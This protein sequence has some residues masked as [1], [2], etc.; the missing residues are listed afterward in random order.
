MNAPKNDNERLI[1]SVNREREAAAE[2][3][4]AR[5]LHLLGVEMHSATSFSAS[6][7]CGWWALERQTASHPIDGDAARLLVAARHHE[8]LEKTAQSVMRVM[9]GPDAERRFEQGGKGC[10]WVEISR[11]G[12]EPVVAHVR[13]GASGRG[14][15]CEFCKQRP[16]VSLCDSP[17]GGPCSKC[18]G[19]GTRAGFNCRDCAG[20]GRAM[21]NRKVCGKCR[22][23]REPD[24]DYCPDHAERA[25]LKP[26]ASPTTEARTA[27][28]AL[29]LKPMRDGCRFPGAC[30]L[31][32]AYLER[33]SVCW[34]SVE[35]RRLVCENCGGEI[36]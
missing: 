32:G 6:C 13:M 9:G 8:H 16:H 1:A 12:S 36:G 35:K 14:V 31:C 30:L 18:K 27:L 7:S 5:P 4:A 23:H 22:Q 15:R 24:E 17:T 19:S 21:C 2:R 11:P 25:G 29:Q 10:H 26:S 3:E 34:F 33:K 20:T 28:R